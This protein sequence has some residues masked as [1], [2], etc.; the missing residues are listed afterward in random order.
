MKLH[1]FQ[2]VSFEDLEGIFKWAEEK[3]HSTSGTLFFE[4]YEF[5][6]IDDF[7]WLIVLGGYMNVYESE[8]FPW[9]VE[10]KEFIRKAISGDK[11]VLGICLGAQLI[12]DVLGGR[13]YRN[14]FTEIGWHSVSLTEDAQQSMVFDSLPD[15]FI[16]FHWHSD[17]FSLP[18]GCRR[19]VE[20]KACENQAFEYNGK[21]MGLQFH[22]E[23]TEE[24]INRLIINCADE[25]SRAELIKETEKMLNKRSNLKKLNRI[26][27]T[28][29]DSIERQFG[30]DF[31]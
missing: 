20:S 26:M 17:T 14:K 27:T 1:F 31:N 12:A 6:E 13:I 5:P 28:F 29:L 19:T 24:S 25:I 15:E 8:K 22:L 30:I 7:D 18:P 11:I 3:G 23:S 9:L 4:D 21:V 16:P 2:Q 10:E